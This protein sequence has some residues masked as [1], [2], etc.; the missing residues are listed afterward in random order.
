MLFSYGI[1]Q[2]G[3]AREYVDV[4]FVDGRDS[5]FAHFQFKY[6]SKSTWYSGPI[7]TT[8]ELKHKS[9]EALQSILLIP[10]TPSPPPPPRPVPLEERP[11]ESLSVEELQKLVRRQRVSLSSGIAEHKTNLEKRE[12]DD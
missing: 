5:P 11:V 7:K 3:A 9:P 4:D 1:K 6:R 12:S 2:P 8:I 10:R